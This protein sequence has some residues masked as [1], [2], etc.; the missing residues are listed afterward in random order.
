MRKKSLT[1]CTQELEL[2]KVA[3]IGSSRH[4]LNKNEQQTGYFNPTQAPLHVK[5]PRKNE[6]YDILQFTW[7][8]N[9]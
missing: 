6:Q 1:P 9:T 2:I 7:K 3:V 4:T 5:P 8:K